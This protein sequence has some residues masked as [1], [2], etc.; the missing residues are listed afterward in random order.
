MKRDRTPRREAASDLKREAGGASVRD[1]VPAV[2][3][4]RGPEVLDVLGVGRQVVRCRIDALARNTVMARP[5]PGQEGVAPRRIAESKTNELG[6]CRRDLRAVE[7]RGRMADAPRVDQK[8]DP[9][10]ALASR[11]HGAVAILTGEVAQDQD[12]IRGGRA[13]RRLDPKHEDADRSISPG[14]SILEHCQEAASDRYDN[15]VRDLVG[16]GCRIKMGT[17]C[18]DGG[19]RGRPGRGRCIGRLAW[20]GPRRPAATGEDDRA[21]RQSGKPSPNAHPSAARCTARPRRPRGPSRDRRR[22]SGQ[23]G[24]SRSACRRPG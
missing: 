23:P 22:R 18:G 20:S 13:A 17:E 24:P 5:N 15:I 4:E 9:V 2:D 7:G 14:R 8:F 1:D 16:A 12:R 21:S 6:A 3:A 19:D 10:G 11:G